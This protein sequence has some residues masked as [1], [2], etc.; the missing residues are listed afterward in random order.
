MKA[1]MIEVKNF[2]EEDNTAQFL[3]EWKELSK[4]DQEEFKTLVGEAIGK[5]S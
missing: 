3:K 4:D 5:T 1:T 2:F